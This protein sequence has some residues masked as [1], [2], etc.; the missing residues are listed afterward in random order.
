MEDLSGLKMT[1]E[2]KKGYLTVLSSLKKKGKT[3]IK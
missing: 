1:D 2:E 3:L